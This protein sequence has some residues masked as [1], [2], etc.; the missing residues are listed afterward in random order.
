MASIKY[1]QYGGDHENRWEGLSQSGY[2]SSLPSYGSTAT[3]SARGEIM[4][5]QQQ[6]QGS[7]FSPFEEN[8]GSAR[9]AGGLMQMGQ[10]GFDWSKQ[11]WD[12]K[13]QYYRTRGTQMQQQAGDVYAGT[14]NLVN[15]QLS[16]R[17]IGGMSGLM[18]QISQNQAGESARQGMVNLYGQGT[19][20]A[21][22]MLGQ[23]SQAMGAAGSLYGGMSQRDMQSGLGSQE[24]YQQG[25]QF[26]QTLDWD[27][28]RYG[29]EETAASDAMWANLLSS[30][31]SAKVTLKCIPEG[32]KIDTPEGRID[33]EELNAGD[34]IIGYDGHPVDIMQKH[35]YKENPESKR[36]LEITF[37][38]NDSVNLC[39]MHRIEHIRSKDYRTG[40]YING[41]KIVNIKWYEG[42][43][44]SYDLFT[45]DGG[46][47][48]GGI[49][50]DS[51]IP[52][53]NALI[54]TL[55]REFIEEGV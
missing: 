12:P 42:V 3:G 16:Q 39:D 36:F 55:S 54:S 4:G 20:Q 19:Q 51:M 40:D 35:Q 43:K 14:A 15:R 41:K 53:M 6:F 33:I 46:Y 13:S 7:G 10:Q 34:I 38:D 22:N 31:V 50:V 27:K 1:Y 28:E 8:P 25:R 9:A 23:A 52:E 5:G 48:I 47:R 32:T 2:G 29:R 18:G 11:L 30:G 44:I 24:L 49:P 21:G 37:D 17:G 26:N 45:K